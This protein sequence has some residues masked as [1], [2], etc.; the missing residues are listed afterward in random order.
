MNPLIE[1]LLLCLVFGSIIGFERL[2]VRHTIGPR[3]IVL[4]VTGSCV[5]TYLGSI[6]FLAS[7]GDLARV[8]AGIIQGLGFIGAGI[9]FRKDEQ[10]QGLTTA[11][12]VWVA[13]GLGIMIGLGIYWEALVLTVYL[14]L[15]M[16][17]LRWAEGKLK[18]K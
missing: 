14:F 7:N 8:P 9:I 4:V 2:K 13:G 18:L 15:I 3:T 1:K 6:M 11:A 5:F 10:I 12:E 17:G 16:V